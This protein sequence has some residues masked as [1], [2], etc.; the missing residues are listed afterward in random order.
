M[1]IPVRYK[2]RAQTK[3]KESGLLMA[4]FA[5]QSENSYPNTSAMIVGE[6]QEGMIPSISDRADTIQASAPIIWTPRFIVL[7][8]LTL[9]IGLSA[10][11]LLTQGWLNGAYRAEWVLLAHTLLILACLV[12]VMVQSR[13]SWLRVGCIFGCI[14]AVFTGASDVMTLLGISGHSLII[15]QLQAAMACALF[16]MYICFSTHHIQFRHWDS[17]F[18]WFAPLIGGSAVALLYVLARTDPHHIRVL[19]NVTITVLLALCVATWW[20]RPSCWRSQP[21]ITFLLGV[22]PLLILLLPLFNTSDFSAYFFFSQVLL[23]C[24]LL[25][26]VRVL[27]GEIQQR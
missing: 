15:L 22:A 11:S 17:I 7:F 4:D 2:E 5:T 3:Y 24:I 13:S 16:A 21:C 27:Q 12:A 19:I 10:E 6:T 14:W 26:V 8:F 25:G 23:L 1:C 20:I 18:F 9:V